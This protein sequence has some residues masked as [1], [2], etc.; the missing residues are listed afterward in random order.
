[1]IPLINSLRSFNFLLFL[2][3]LASLDLIG[4]WVFSVWNRLGRLGNSY[5]LAVITVKFLFYYL[6]P[7]SFCTRTLWKSE[8]DADLRF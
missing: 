4:G 6:M 1:M 5:F 7:I 3:S 2:I 8:A